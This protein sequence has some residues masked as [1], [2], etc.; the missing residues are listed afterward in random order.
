[1]TSYQGVGANFIIRLNS[2]G[3]RDTSFNVGTGFN[4]T[5]N[6]LTLQSDGKI[7]VGGGFTSYQ[8]VEANR[9][10]R[11]NS[12][13]SRDTSFNMGT[14]FSN[15]VDTLAL[16]SDGKILVGGQFTSY[17]GVGANYI[18]RLN[19]DG[20]RD[21]SF[22]MGT[23]FSNYVDTLALQSDGKILVGGW[24]T[25]YQGVGANYIIRLNS[26]GS[27][28]TSFNLGTGFNDSIASLAL[29]SDGKIL[30]GGYFTNYQD[31]LAGYLIRVGD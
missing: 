23:G 29:Q 26:D 22:N 15:Y 20:S 7:L 30:V 4:N 5:V 12:D 14:G 24:F 31:Q 3:S 21:T 1:F 28:D 19:S 10:I 13:G 2:D 25:S 27:R 18:I 16:Q 11:L 17:Q 6:T 9:I 8:G